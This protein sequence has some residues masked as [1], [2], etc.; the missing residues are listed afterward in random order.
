MATERKRY[1]RVADAVGR[2]TWTNDELACFVRLLA[3][4]NSR[5]S[6]DRLDPGQACRATLRIEEV[7]AMSG[8]R[9]PDVART[10][11]ERCAIVA[12]ISVEHRGNVSLIEWPKLAEFQ[13]WPSEVREQP[14]QERGTMTPLPD[15]G[16]RSPS[17][18]YEESQ[19]AAAP[20][21]VI[22]DGEA[23]QPERAAP[24]SVKPP[25]AP[26][27]L[28]Q[29]ATLRDAV[30]RRWPQAA[31]PQSLV[32]W[33]REIERLKAPPAQVAELLA[34]L[35][36]PLRDADRYVPEVRCARSFRAKWNALVAARAR[37]QRGP[38]KSGAQERYERILDAGRGALEL[39]K[40][41]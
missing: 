37:S 38:P 33:A 25:P 10:L 12:S 30:R 20:P 27:A 24:A 35:V 4:M 16:L 9:R 34:W 13:G 8:K 29:A 26:R 28:E 7:M 6:R 15:S 21:C 5:R 14:G 2:E 22:P 23:Q 39:L 17:P 36:D 40:D 41:L 19:T 31:V 18:Y 32:A 11:L 1:F 3:Y